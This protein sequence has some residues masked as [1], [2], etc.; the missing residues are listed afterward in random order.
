MFGDILLVLHQLV[1]Q[2][3]DEESAPG[4]QLLRQQMDD[5]HGQ[6]EAVQVVERRMSKGVVMVPSS[7]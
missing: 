7:I 5:I 4:A 3:L 6:V 1:L 2:L